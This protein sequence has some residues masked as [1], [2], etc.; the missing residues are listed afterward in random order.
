M[1]VTVSRGPFTVEIVRVVL[2]QLKGE[3]LALLL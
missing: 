1:V 3:I 2:L